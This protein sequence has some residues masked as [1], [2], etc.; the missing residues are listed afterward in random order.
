MAR[1]VRCGGDPHYHIQLME[2]R[3]YQNPLI[4]EQE[5]VQVVE[6][7][8]EMDVCRDCARHQLR[9]DLHLLSGKEGFQLGLV[10]MMT[11]LCL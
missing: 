7:T 9:G 6:R 2:V 4:Y 5:P 3:T 1:C 11:V 10:A 8:V